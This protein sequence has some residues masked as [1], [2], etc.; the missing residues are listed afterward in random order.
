[1]P[2]HVLDW[3]SSKIHRV[4]RSPLA[5]EAASA[6]QAH[7]RAQMVRHTLAWLLTEPPRFGGWTQTMRQVAYVLLTDYH[8]LYEHCSKAT[9]TVS[10]RRVALDLMDV[11][12]S[13]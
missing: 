4:V 11:R 3:S 7:D 13:I 10:E 5:A 2:V 6:A 1:M 8:S 9:S 12:S